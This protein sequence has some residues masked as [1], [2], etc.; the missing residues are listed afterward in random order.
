MINR[1]PL[2]TYVAGTLGSEVYR[3]WDPAALRAQAVVTR[4]YALY[5]RALRAGRDSTSRRTPSHQVYG[6]V[7]VEDEALARAVA[8]TRARGA[9]VARPADPRRVPLGVGRAHRERGGGLGRGAARIC[10]AST[11]KAKRSRPTPTGAC[12][13]RARARARARA[14]RA[15]PRRS[16]RGARGRAH[17][18]RARR[19]RRAH[20]LE[21]QRVGHRA[22]AALARSAIR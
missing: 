18:E 22:R 3:R 2:E 10:A 17:T 4:T 9:H 15:A 20:G 12:A 11:S 16:A 13:S 6:G 1:V 8:D 7:R 19:A 5:Q 14:A 21:R